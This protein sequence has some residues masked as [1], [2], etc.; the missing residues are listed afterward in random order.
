MK[1]LPLVLL[2]ATVTA[3]PFSNTSDVPP[4]DDT[5]KHLKGG[6]RRRILASLGEDEQT[7]S[8]IAEIIDRRSQENRRRLQTAACVTTSTYQDIHND[9]VSLSQ[10]I[11]GNRDRGHFFGGIVRLAAHDFMDY[12]I[13]AIGNPNSQEL[14]PDGCLDFDHSANAGLPDLWCDDPNACPFKALYD[15]SYS[16]MSK[17][18]FWVAA[19]NAVIDHT[20]NGAL[21]L[22]FRWGR[23]DTNS[24]A[25]S[26]ERLPEPDGC[27]EVRAT[28]ID[29]M[30]LTW[31]D[32]VA[33]SGGHTLGRGD[34]R[35]SGHDGTWVD[36][37]RESTI[38]DKRYYEEVVRR[39]WRPR[40]TNV[41]VNW[42]WGGNNRGVMMLNTDICLLFDIPNG[43]NQN[44]CTN[45]NTDC[46][47]SSIQNNQCVSA[48]SVRPQA[49]A[50]F[51]EFLG[52]GNPNNSNQQPFYDGFSTS[53]TLATEIGYSD[54]TLF[55]LADTCAPAPTPTP[56]SGTPAPVA[57]PTPVAKSNDA[58]VNWTWGGN[59]RGVMMLNTD[60]CLF[61]DIPEGDVQNC[62][63]DTSGNCR[64]NLTQNNQCPTADDVRP[65]AIAAFRE[66]LGGENL[67]ND[68]QEPFFSAYSEAWELA[69][70]NG[71][72]DD[73]LFDLA[74]TCVP[75]TP[76][77]PTPTVPPVSPAPV[78]RTPGPVPAPTTSTPAPTTSTPAPSAPSPG[79]C[80][81]FEGSFEVLKKDGSIKLTTCDQISLD[82]CAKHGHLCRKTCGVCEC[83]TGKMRCTTDSDCCSGECK[84]D[85]RCRSEYRVRTM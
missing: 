27:N 67:N 13:N 8:A 68:N 24:C 19:A 37:D 57:N 28:F 72:S 82:K 61:F 53:W 3:C 62:C 81:D 35:F 51:R 70:E 63:T 26:S 73:N 48:E 42:T 66:F 34:I 52:G 80:E 85:G 36:S 38:F 4:N 40:Q 6:R 22:P 11:N 71:Y 59:N 76:T 29:R 12:D 17:A 2:I 5:H 50:A 75:T 1:V 77:T 39:A 83:L 44:C 64:D 25:E 14:G 21:V 10:T 30:G 20:S 58:G 41:G 49:V 18:D 9:V 45:T 32:A 15:S 33:L 65:E 84:D 56:P 47:D 79:S 23:I 7:R 78:I 16:F 43:N 60:I 54:D 74:D 55:D 69:T 31:R 46:R